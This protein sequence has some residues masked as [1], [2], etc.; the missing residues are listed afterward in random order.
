MRLFLLALLVAAPAL[1]QDLAITDVYV[2]DVE[3]GVT[4]AG[5]TVVVTDGRITAVGSDAALPS[6]VEVV[7]GGGGYLLPGLIDMHAHLRHPAAPALVMPQLVAHGVTGVREMGSECE[8][9]EQG[10]CIS[11]LRAW[12][13]QIEAG[14]RVGPRLLQLSSFPLNPPW[15]YEVSE[16]Q[17][18]GIVRELHGRGVD[19]IKTYYRLSP[20]AFGWVVDEAN[21]LG[22]YAAGHLPL[23]MTT[24]E[25]AAAGVRSVEHTRDLLFDC[26]PGSAAFRSEARSQNPPPDVL[27]AM[28]EEHDPDTCAETFEAMVA[29]GTAY[30][31]THVTRR[32]DAFADD[33]TFR[34]DPR[35]RTLPTVVWDQWQA[36]ADRMV[37]L[38][39]SP[40]GR[41]MAKAFH[42]LGL[43]LTGRA[44]AAGVTVLLGTDGGDTYSF[45]G[46]SAH[47]ELALLVEAGLTPAEALAAATLRPAEFMGIEAD[48]GTVAVGKH[49][50]LVLLRADPLADV[51]NVRQIEAVIVG[52]RL[53]DRSALD[54]LMADVEAFVAE[55][56]ARGD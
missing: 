53:F 21:A 33:P 56:D 14:E 23:A 7:D 35:R 2:V 54:A 51:E 30:V 22:I 40:E 4:V 47:D 18:R 50:D 17:A 3:A 5:Q 8:N 48:Y 42:E 24:A 39:P 34:D 12:G 11:D 28:V 9:P 45:F 13:E 38:D 52:G 43:E 29:Y 49:A 32:M 27:R 25:A 55:M 36:D 26:F 31:P 41:A 6:G 37:A 15:D 46:S 1:A 44:H 10:P 20:E 16:E 19:L